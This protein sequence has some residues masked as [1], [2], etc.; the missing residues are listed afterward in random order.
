MKIILTTLLLTS[1]IASADPPALES[2]RKTYSEEQKKLDGKYVAWLSKMVTQVTGD[3]QEAYRKELASVR[4][5]SSTDGDS[6]VGWGR[7]IK[8]AADNADGYKLGRLKQ[9]QTVR[10][11]YEAG[12]WSAY[13]GWKEESPD[14]AKRLEHKLAFV[15]DS[16]KGNTTITTP[17]DT[18]DKPFEYTIVEDG[19]YFIRINDPAID[20]NKGVV[21]YRIE[22]K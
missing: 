12:I 4:G 17:Q 11:M 7:S 22:I 1:L 2:A 8:I 6:A 13:S 10:I 16:R 5:E 18:K 19:H 21:Q 20:S 15:K 3:D 14:N 9:G